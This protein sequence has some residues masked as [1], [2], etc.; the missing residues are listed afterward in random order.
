MSASAAVW[1]RASGYPRG[2]RERRLLMVLQAV[3]DDSG[4]FIETKNPAFVLAGFLADSAAWASLSDDWQTILDDSPRLSYFKM[5]EANGLRGQYA[6]QFGWNDDLV[7][8]RLDRFVEIIKKHVFVRL[9]VS[10]D[11]A[12]FNQVVRRAYFSHRT[13]NTDTPYCV[14][15]QRII[16]LLPAAQAS[17]HDIFGDSPKSVDFIFDEQGEIGIEAQKTW[18]DIKR[19]SERLAQRGRTDFR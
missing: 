10:V 7:D 12:A 11:K 1:D 16:M 8:D 15:F 17:R 19:A 13:H 5:A 3:L 6:K 2:V 9:T 14:A 4:G 18:L